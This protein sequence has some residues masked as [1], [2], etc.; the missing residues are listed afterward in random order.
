[1]DTTLA[2]VLILAPLL[3]FLL[4]IFFGKQLGKSL[5]G[6]IGTLT[7]FISF[8]A[9]AYFFGGVA[10]QPEGIRISLFEWIQIS[11]FKV[12]F[13]FQLDQLSILWLMFVTG[14]GTLIHLY[15]ISYMHDDEN[16]HTFFGYLNL[17]IFFMISLVIGSNL[18]IMFIGWEG[19]GLS[20]Y[21]L[22]GFWYKNQDFNDAAK[23]AFI[24]NRI[25]DLGLLVGIFIVGYLFNTINFAELQTIFLAGGLEGKMTM[26]SIAALALFIG[27]AGKSA[28]I[29]LYTW[30]PDAMAGPTPVSALIHAAT[31]VTAGIF[32]ITR[33]HFL[34]DLAPVVQNAIAII[35]AITS[36]VA[37]TIALVQTDIKKVLAY[38]TV[39]QL[40]LMFLALG[41][42]AYEIAVFHVITHAFFKACLF[43]GSG[44]VI[45]A[46]HEQDMRKMGGLRKAMPITFITMLLSSLA[47]SGIFPLAGFWSK[48]EI[49][50]T[51]FHASP[52]LWVIGSLASMFTAF[53]MFRLMFLTFFKDFRGTEEQKHHLH[54]SP[55]LITFPLIV[56]AILATVGGL[57]SL[58]GNSWLNHY[59]MPF[60]AKEG[61]EAHALGQTE[62]MLMAIA[63]VGALI[64][65]GVAYAKYMKQNQVPGA[66]ATFTGMSKVLYNKYYVDE[67]YDAVFVKPINGLSN[68]FRDYIETGLS[69]LVFGFGKVA[70]ELSFQGKK[71]HTGSIGF[72][73]FVFVLG[74][75]AIISY[76][77]IEL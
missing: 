5:S 64:G 73:L 68:F 39:S 75:C 41:L 1:M 60:F 48:D 6:I 52:A 33:L 26:I 24:M 47:I 19:V 22:I 27:A 56:L 43:L 70:N 42:G 76:L 11:N 28:Q 46:L 3:G 32:M 55:A 16:M 25:G 36:L 34:F 71:L 38:S 59:L 13:G 69:A 66:D 53:Y 29:P 14:I 12:D 17:F 74:F 30:L 10:A 40:G 18:L 4:N 62:Y 20:S 77:F 8:I 50:M 49:L 15:S 2:L 72:Y 35:G 63:T 58:P 44:S 45:H 65:I 7:V 23:K 9:T 54:E 61:H 21:L 51:A 67:I 31:M 57:I 37:A